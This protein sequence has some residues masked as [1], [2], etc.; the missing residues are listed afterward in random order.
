MSNCK[1]ANCLNICLDSLKDHG[2]DDNGSLIKEMLCFPNY[3]SELL[4]EKAPNLEEVSD[5]MESDDD[6]DV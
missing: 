2:C 5:E 3:V 1:R 4:F 6:S